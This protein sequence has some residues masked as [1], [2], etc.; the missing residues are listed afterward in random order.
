MVSGR[1]VCSWSD[2]VD[3]CLPL[4][5][6][7]LY[8]V[9]MN[10]DMNNKFLSFF[11]GYFQNIWVRVENT[12]YLFT[13]IYIPL[14]SKNITNTKQNK[15]N[16][17]DTSFPPTV[18]HSHHSRDN[19][20]QTSIIYHFRYDNIY[21]LRRQQVTVMGRGWRRVSLLGRTIP[22]TDL[23]LSKSHRKNFLLC[24]RYCDFSVSYLFYKCWSRC[25]NIRMFLCTCVCFDIYFLS[26]IMLV[27][28]WVCEAYRPCC[29]LF[30]FRI[31]TEC[32]FFYCIHAFYLL[33]N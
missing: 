13:C 27:A 17:E 31:R 4:V 18:N 16:K 8:F 14:S 3:R 26:G 33:V 9:F 2:E 7:F 28:W 12:Q 11:F 15:Q 30:V 22:C 1:D 29:S 21:L 5:F 24:G 23:A 6:I 25:L 20:I 19:E 10:E 32:I